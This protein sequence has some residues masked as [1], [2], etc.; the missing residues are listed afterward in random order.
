M[1]LLTKPVLLIINPGSRRAARLR[2]QAES[3]FARAGVACDPVLTERPGHAAQLAA[4]R[5]THYRAIFALG[6]DGTAM[7]V[8]GALAYSG[9]PVG[10]LPGGTGNLVARALHVPLSVRAAVPALLSGDVATLD[11]GVLGNGRRFAFSAGVGVDARMIAETPPAWKRRFGIP[12]YA[13]IAARA[14]L[15]R[16]PFVVRADVDGVVVEREATAVI[17][18]NFGSVLNDLITLGPGIRQDDGRLDL[19]IFSPRTAPDAVRLVWRLYQGRFDDDRRLLYRSGH[20]FRLSCDP[21]QV[22]QADGEVLGS[23]PFEASVEPLAATV[24]LPRRAHRRTS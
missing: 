20:S 3:A 16:R 1:E 4:E 5:A 19:C 8:V 9:M 15:R 18:A 2:A 13:L 6:G 14:V 23:T 17:I 11:L 24:L 10:V 22:L 12:A 7:E 21:P